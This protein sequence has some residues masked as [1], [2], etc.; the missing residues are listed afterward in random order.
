VV[1][2]TGQLSELL[3]QHRIKGGGIPATHE[4]VFPAS[5]GGFRHYARLSDILA[6]AAQE[7]GVPVKVGPQVL[8]RTYNTLGRTVMN[9]ETLQDLMGHTSD[10][11]TQRYHRAPLLLKA[12][13]MGRF[14]EL[15][16]Q[17]GNTK[18]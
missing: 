3:R 18:R 13:A 16:L 6:M 12:E 2:L 4:L 1:P 9:T 11:M 7:A 8:R 15:I 17:G 14:E 10:E 5:N